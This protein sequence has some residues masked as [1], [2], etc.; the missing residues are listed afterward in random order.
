[1]AH[2]IPAQK[3]PLE[4]GQLGGVGH[5]GG[6]GVQEEIIVKEW[7]PIAYLRP[8]EFGVFLSGDRASGNSFG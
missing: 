2:H 3:N 8:S 7:P 4:F 1:L 6:L 5:L